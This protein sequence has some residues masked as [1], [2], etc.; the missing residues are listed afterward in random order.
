MGKPQSILMSAIIMATLGWGSSIASAASFSLNTSPAHDQSQTQVNKGAP[1]PVTKTLVATGYGIDN[2]QALKMAFRT[3]IEQYVG[4]V[5]DSSSIVKNSELID[6]SLLTASSGYI[7]T[8]KILSTSNQND[9]IAIKIM[10]TVQSQKLIQ[11]I[12]KLNIATVT[13]SGA[14]DIG[15]RVETKHIAKEDALK[16]LHKAWG[17]AWS[18]QAL[19]DMLTVK[20]DS[21]KVMEDEAEGDSVPLHIQAS[22]HVDDAKYKATIQKLETLF[23]Q[24]GAKVHHRYDLPKTIRNSGNMILQ[25]SNKERMDKIPS[26]SIV[27]LKH[28]GRGLTIDVWEFPKS[29][30]VNPT[31]PNYTFDKQFHLALEVNDGANNVL[32]AN[33]IE[34]ESRSPMHGYPFPPS[35]VNLFFTYYNNSYH[36]YLHSVGF[37]GGKGLHVFGPFLFLGHSP[38]PYAEPTSLI[39]VSKTIP[40][41][42]ADVKKIGNVTVELERK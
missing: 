25:V 24:L 7:Q 17:E 5:V 28:Y 2:A 40:I 39:K 34:V 32:Y 38:Y 30:K 31:T 23:I 42:L 37:L 6:D 29:W 35:P 4:V 1:T 9:L 10:A 20:I 11:S 21:V 14:K 18:D 8:Y 19:Q 33:Y 13:I 41:N 22:V 26:S 36:N 15:A 3:A 16:M 12:H 27:L